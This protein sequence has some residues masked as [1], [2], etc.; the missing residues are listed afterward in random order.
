MFQ[1]HDKLMIESLGI[2]DGFSKFHATL[3]E[4][5]AIKMIRVYADLETCFKRVK[6]RN[7]AEHIAVSDHRVVE[8]NQIAATV[9]YDWDLEINNND[10]A[11]DKDI[12][13]VIQSI[14]YAAA[15]A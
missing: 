7:Y 3:A 9:N 4:K 5:Y 1:T 12:V 15:H 14:N 6:T 13:A 11:T 8:L 10:L 2:G